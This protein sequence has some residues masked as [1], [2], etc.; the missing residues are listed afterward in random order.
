MQPLISVIIPV[1][2]TNKK[3]VQQC[4]N[5]II[6]QTYSNW[7]CVFVDNGSSLDYS[8]LL[9]DKRVVY[10]RIEDNVGIFLAYKHGF[11][12]S[13]GQYLVYCDSDD[14]LHKDYLQQLVSHMD[15]KYDTY[16]MGT[17]S[18]FENGYQEKAIWPNKG[19]KNY[20]DLEWFDAL[21]SRKQSSWALWGKLLK[22]DIVDKVYQSIQVIHH[23]VA[24]H[25]LLL[26]TVYSFFSQSTKSVSFNGFYYRISNQSVS[27]SS[28]TKDKLQNILKDDKLVFQQ[29]DSF[30]E[31]N[32]IDKTQLSKI[33]AECGENFINAFYT[34]NNNNE[35]YPLFFTEVHN[36]Y[37]VELIAPKKNIVSRIFPKDSMQ[38][39]FF[40]FLII[41]L[42]RTIKLREI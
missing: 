11:E 23:I 35:L 1:Y 31:H 29:L 38:Y 14:W 22:R 42:Y 26:I 39:K 4:L 24:P 40:R 9:T 18:V 34:Y 30:L 28:I 13:K 37:G 33:K 32:N 6:N 2:N 21:C 16:F 19:L 41:K 12:N 20:T 25:D 7:E 17:I 36:V 27:R 15:P 10:T 3:Y 5:S 8:D